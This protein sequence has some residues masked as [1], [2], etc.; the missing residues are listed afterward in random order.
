MNQGLTSELDEEDEGESDRGDEGPDRVL[1]R[2][3][4]HV[5]A[6][7][8][9]SPAPWGWLKMG[10]DGDTLPGLESAFIPNLSPF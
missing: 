3:C 6:A 7:S 8:H 4:C 2:N 1:W 10:E 5:S 9:V